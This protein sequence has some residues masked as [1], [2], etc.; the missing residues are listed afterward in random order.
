MSEPV[1]PAA[2]RGG[3]VLLPDSDLRAVLEQAGFEVVVP[4]LGG[5]PTDPEVI[6][7]LTAARDLLPA[8]PRFVVGTGNG[9]LYARIAA[10]AVLGL[11][12]AVSFGGRISYAGVNIRQPIQPMD[13]LPGLSCPLQCHF[14]ADDP[15]APAAHVDELERRLAGT[16]R[17]WQLFRYGARTDEDQ[18]TAR[19]RACSFLLHLAAERT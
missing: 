17:P 7:L 4:D 18:R 8:G 15:A 14:E 11:A 2:P 10:C 9:G 3:V 16:S 12:G 1:V 19:G 5:D 6:R 13:L